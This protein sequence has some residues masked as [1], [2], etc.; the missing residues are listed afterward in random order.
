MAKKE[1]TIS[2]QLSTKQA[3][4][5]SR[6][7]ELVARLYM[8][9]VEELRFISKASWEDCQKIKKMCFPELAANEYYGITSEIGTDEP[10]QLWDIYQVLRHYLA[11][12]DQPN[13]PETRKWPEQMQVQF[14][15]PRRTSVECALPRIK[16]DAQEIS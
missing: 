13:T 12:K 2:L 4:T 16:S 7:C 10:N 8:G 9:Q 6:A 15:K 1:D 14:D 3:Q 11:W 5:L